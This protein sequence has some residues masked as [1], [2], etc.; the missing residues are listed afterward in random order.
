MKVKSPF[1]FQSEARIKGKIT[2]EE[3][4]LC[5]LIHKQKAGQFPTVHRKLIPFQVCD[6]WMNVKLSLD[7]AWLELSQEIRLNL[8]WKWAHTHK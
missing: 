4:E 8:Q 7:A 5:S 2:Q 3:V 1:Q 6:Y